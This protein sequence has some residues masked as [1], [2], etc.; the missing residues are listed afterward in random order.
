MKRLTLIVVVMMVLSIAFA[1]PALA[2][3]PPDT[4]IEIGVVAPGDVDADI[5]L[6]A[7]GN[8]DVSINGAGLV[9]ADVLQGALAANAGSPYEDFAY[10][11][12]LYGYGDAI[13]SQFS[14]VNDALMLL[15][16]QMVED[17][18]ITEAENL[19]LLEI[20]ESFKVS[21]NAEIDSIDSD[22]TALQEQAL[23]THNQLWFGAEHDISII[24]GELGSQD[25]DID[26]LY[27]EIGYRS[28]LIN[29]ANDRY[30][31]LLAYTTD[32]ENR[33]R[34]YLLAVCGGFLVLL[35]LVVVVFVRIRKRSIY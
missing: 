11:W 8:L 23:A 15:Y 26:Y 6:S 34:N 7:G 28:N 20:I 10:Y 29:D 18:K 22:I 21:T 2:Q 31:S 12:R 9:N 35:A 27:R 30:G 32:L 5:N 17:G 13:G 25:S 16:N 19:K 14:A 4:K 33:M 24:Y 3:E 1:T